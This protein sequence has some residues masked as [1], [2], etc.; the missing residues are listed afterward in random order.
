MG[1]RGLVGYWNGGFLFGWWGVLFLKFVVYFFF[2]LLEGAGCLKWGVLVGG[3]IWD[4]G[5]GCLLFGC[6]G[7]HSA[8]LSLI[9]S[10]KIR[11]FEV[12]I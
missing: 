6:W 2:F 12:L 8:I 3:S 7:G 4:V 5:V 10:W 9:L 11:G 1:V